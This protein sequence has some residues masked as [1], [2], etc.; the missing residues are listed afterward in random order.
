MNDENRRN[1]HYSDY[2]DKLI[3]LM[4]NNG[5]TADE[6]AASLGNGRTIGGVQHRISYLLCERHKPSS[7]I[8]DEEAA[9]IAKL[10][11]KG[12]CSSEICQITGRSDRTVA[13]IS[14]LTDVIL[15]VINE[16]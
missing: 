10:H 8:S 9:E 13:R 4:H 6:I 15:K 16:L 1:L 3:L 5:K 7:N 12:K 14:R 11:M 2:E